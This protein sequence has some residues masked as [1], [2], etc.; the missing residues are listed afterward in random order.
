MSQKKTIGWQGGSVVKGTWVSLLRSTWWKER[1]DSHKLSDL[2]MHTLLYP[3]SIHSS[4]HACIDIIKTFQKRL[5]ILG[6]PQTHNPPVSASCLLGLQA[7]NIIAILNLIIYLFLGMVFYLVKL[8]LKLYRPRWSQIHGVPS[9][10]PL[11]CWDYRHVSPCP[12]F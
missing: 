12:A 8:G 6:C 4:I 11:E 3:P 2:H 10:L 7:C 1:G 9:A 5:Y